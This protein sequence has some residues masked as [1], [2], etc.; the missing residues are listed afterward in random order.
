MIGILILFGIF[1]LFAIILSFYL[2]KYHSQKSLTPFTFQS[3]SFNPKNNKIPTEDACILKEE[4]KVYMTFIV[5]AYNE[6]KRIERMLENT[7]SYCLNRYE[8]TKDTLKPFTFEIIVVDDGSKDKTR[9]VVVGVIQKYN[10]GNADTNCLLL[11]PLIINQGKGFA[12]KQGVLRSRGS[13]ILMLDADGATEIK[14][15]EKLESALNTFR[16]EDLLQCESTHLKNQTKNTSPS[17][18]FNVALGSRRQLESDADRH[19]LRNLMSVGFN[20]LVK[21]ISGIHS[22][23]DTQCGFK[24]FDRSAARYL[25]INQHC[26]RWCFDIDLLILCQYHRNPEIK[27]KEVPVRWQE[28]AGSHL[29][30]G[31]LLGILRDLFLIRLYYELGFWKI[32]GYNGLTQEGSNKLWIKGYEKIA[33]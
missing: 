10:L 26:E 3:Y 30:I 4:S 32:L 23:K 27:I 16:Q 11:L 33:H 14:D 20:F 31:G 7:L 12:V 22:V 19:W 29:T 9:D 21:Y 1:I 13:R 5:P 25:F 8:N 17:P 24:M 18:S 6:E 2:L 15:I 28:I